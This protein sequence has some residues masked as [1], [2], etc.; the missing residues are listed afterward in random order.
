MDTNSESNFEQDVYVTTATL[1]L[2][3][4]AV[5]FLRFAEKL[6]TYDVSLLP[7]KVLGNLLSK[8]SQGDP[9]LSFLDMVCMF[10]VLYDAGY[11][12]KTVYHAD[13]VIYIKITKKGKEYAHV[14]PKQVTEFLN[15]LSPGFQS[16]AKLN[17]KCN[18]RTKALTR[19]HGEL[20]FNGY[21]FI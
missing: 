1:N 14:K 8:M 7:A 15:S 10:S 21:M 6:E 5:N 11:L 12:E 3:S 13:G 17:Q 18:E 9:V 16:G 19:V 4:N 2:I 20:Q